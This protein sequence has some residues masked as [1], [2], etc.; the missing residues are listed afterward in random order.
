MPVY[1]DIYVEVKLTE[2][3]YCIRESLRNMMGILLQDANVNDN[4][5]FIFYSDTEIR[6]FSKLVGLMLNADAKDLSLSQLNYQTVKN[7]I[8]AMKKFEIEIANTSEKQ[9]EEEEHIYEK[10]EKFSIKEKLSGLIDIHVKPWLLE[11]EK[12]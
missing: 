12:V 11:S 8:L 6:E 3:S 1:G 9:E 7:S 2:L 10:N 5:N 4:V